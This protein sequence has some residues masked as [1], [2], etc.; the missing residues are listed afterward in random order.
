MVGR[1]EEGSQT[2]IFSLKNVSVV[3]HSSCQSEKFLCYDDSAKIKFGTIFVN[4]C[5]KM[6]T[7][8][9]KEHT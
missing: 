1:T 6:S 2:K 3:I 4:R 8:M 9:G 7:K 5:V